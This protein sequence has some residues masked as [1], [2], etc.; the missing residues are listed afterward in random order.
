M[1]EQSARSLYEQKINQY[2][3]SL[4]PNGAGTITET[5]LRH[6]LDNVAQTAFS[7][8]QD[9]ALSSLLTVNDVAELFGVN[10]SRVRAIAKQKHEQFGIGYQIPNTNQWLFRPSEIESLR[11][12]SVGRPRKGA[13]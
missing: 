2:V 11:P 12:G 13:N 5:K 7:V 3:Q 4:L 10:V 6:V 8:G 1:D 9:Y